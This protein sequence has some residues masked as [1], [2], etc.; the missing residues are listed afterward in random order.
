MYN[1]AMH[2]EVLHSAPHYGFDFPGGKPPKFQWTALKA[3]R[4]AYI[5]K[6]NGIYERNLS[7][8]QVDVVMGKASFV[9]NAVVK[10]GDVEYSADHILS[11][12]RLSQV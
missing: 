7:R 8:D 3:K 4:D 12:F 9:S 10:V 5:R 1:A 6:L 2:R 11:R